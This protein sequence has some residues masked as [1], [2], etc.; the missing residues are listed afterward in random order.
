MKYFP[1][2]LLIAI[3]LSSS[4]ITTLTII[5]NLEI[6]VLDQTDSDKVSLNNLS[7]TITEKSDYF[8]FCFEDTGKIS[9]LIDFIK[10][11]KLEEAETQDTISL[12]KLSDSISS[13][14]SSFSESSISSEP[15][16]QKTICIRI[17]K[18]LCSR[19]FIHCYIVTHN[20]VD[21]ILF[22]FQQI[23]DLVENNMLDGGVMKG[24]RISYIR[25]EYVNLLTPR[26]KKTRI[27]LYYE[28][29]LFYCL[30]L[31][32]DEMSNEARLSDDTDFKNK[33]KII[34]N[35]SVG[36]INTIEV[37]FQQNRNFYHYQIKQIVD[38]GPKKMH[39]LKGSPFKQKLKTNLIIKAD[40]LLKCNNQQLKNNIREQWGEYV[41]ILNL[42]NPTFNKRF[43]E[44][45]F[46]LYISKLLFNNKFQS[47]IEPV[48]N[49]LQEGAVLGDILKG[50]RPEALESKLAFNTIGLSVLKKKCYQKEKALLSDIQSF[51]NLIK[52]H[53]E[54]TLHQLLRFLIEAME[55][56]VVQ[57]KTKKVGFKFDNNNNNNNK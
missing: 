37:H 9:T 48:Y 42:Y 25:S 47:Y 2:F 40:N 8:E 39:K 21:L 16:V 12:P 57:Q 13:K 10:K 46:A 18:F 44:P 50:D 1:T 31:L 6:V 24:Y 52:L 56:V 5:R 34:R 35:S 55:V 3:T 53:I 29:M 38:R 54:E 43:L 14:V 22:T 17:F 4:L 32:F 49:L 20:P 36:F 27:D 7:I 30:N 19:L 45:L 15:R 28:K 11:H 41:D 33:I 51:E 23:S 26:S